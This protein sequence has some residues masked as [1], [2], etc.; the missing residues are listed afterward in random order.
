MG[1]YLHG[2][3]E[4]PEACAALLARCGLVS[5]GQAVDYAVH[6]QRE[7]DRLAECLEAHLDMAAL[8]R[9]LAF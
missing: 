2:L 8:G 3:F 5:N 7:L 6:R 1:T 4:R 9:L